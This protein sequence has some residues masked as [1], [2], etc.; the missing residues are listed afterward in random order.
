MAEHRKPAA[1]S[2]TRKQRAATPTKR[3]RAPRAQRA[4]T[5]GR[6]APRASQARQNPPLPA[7]LLAHFGGQEHVDLIVEECVPA[8]ASAGDVLRL[9]LEARR[10]RANPL[11]RD[12]FLARGYARDGGDFTYE[13]AARRDALLAYAKRQSGFLGHDE[14]AIFSEDTF[15]RGA[16]DADA[17]TLAARAGI[18]HTTGMPGTRGTLVGAWCVAEMQGEPPT[19]RILDAAEYVGAEEERETRDPEDPVRRHPDLCMVAAAMSNALRI[20]AGLN[21]VVGAEELT[22]RPEPLPQI[23][24]TAPAVFEEGPVD[25]IDER[26]LDAYRQ[27][28][29]L[30]A[31]LCTPA[32]LRAKL[33]SAKALADDAGGDPAILDEQRIRIAEELERAV[34]A[35][36]ARRHDP[37]KLA[38]RLAELRAFDPEDLDADA[39]REYK[40]ER[41]AV[42]AMAA[43]HG[44]DVPAA[45]A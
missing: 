12:V 11:R 36:T 10:L 35:E 22:R 33:A 3:A 1:K 31:M 30:D 5:P 18:T 2:T 13:V 19:V 39:L 23:A 44:I 16:P 7:D 17:K 26:I 14:A 27:A 41:A 8:D 34:A 28:Q 15:Q 9:L 45:T 32:K 20:A 6:A 21:D 43:A 42:E 29:A 40:T 38:R 4:A 24:T 37:A 25:D